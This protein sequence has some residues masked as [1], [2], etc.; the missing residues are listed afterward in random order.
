MVTVPAATMLFVSDPVESFSFLSRF[1]P[2]PFD[3]RKTTIEPTTKSACAQPSAGR[4][5]ANAVI[6][7]PDLRTRIVLCEAMY[8]QCVVYL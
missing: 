8:I 6:V 5:A 2:R 3:D 7:L 1:L 4:L